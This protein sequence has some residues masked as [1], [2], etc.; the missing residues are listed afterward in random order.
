MIKVHC[1]S[2]QQIIEGQQMAKTGASVRIPNVDGAVT[3]IFNFQ[4]KKP[5]LCNRCL[6]APFAQLIDKNESTVIPLTAT[7]RTS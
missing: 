6:L 1:N 7:R 4:G 2:C 5:D 3:A